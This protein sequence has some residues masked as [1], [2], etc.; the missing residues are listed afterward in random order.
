MTEYDATM[1]NVDVAFKPEALTMTLTAKETKAKGKAK[2]Q[3]S[4]APQEA[5]QTNPEEAQSAGGY[6]LDDLLG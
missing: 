5:P 3:K 1:P 4:E 6:N 2:P